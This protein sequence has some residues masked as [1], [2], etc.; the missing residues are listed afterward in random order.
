VTDRIHLGAITQFFPAA[1]VEQ[2]L[3]ETGRQS[4]RIRQ[5]PARVMVYYVIA[6]A[7]WMDVSCRE[8]LRCLLEGLSP[9]AGVER[10]RRSARSAISM[11][12]GRLGPEPLQ[13]LLERCVGPIATPATRGAWYRGLRLVSLDGSSLDVADTP[14][15]AR[16]FGRPGASRGDSAYPKLRFV[17]L[18]ESGT[19][20]L[21]RTAWGGFREAETTLA[22]RLL[23]GL[24]PGM[25][26][27]ADRGF[28]GFALWQA[29][30]ATGA[31]LVWRVKRNL[32]LPCERCL[33]DGSY[34][35]QIFPSQSDRRRRRGG[36]PVRVIEY[37]AQRARGEGERIRLI[38][39]LLDE[40]RAPA[41]ELAALYHERW[42]IENTLDELKTHLRG[43]QIVLRSQKPDLVEQEFYGL[44]LAHF[45][46][47][48]LMHEAAHRE[49]IDPDTLSFVHSFR[50][51]KRKL[52]AFLALPPSGVPQAA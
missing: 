8:V 6:M 12:R 7:L 1:Q 33:A 37:V 24:R 19:H 39:T 47:R 26:C 21:F 51:V 9:L 46:I 10:I 2:I 44:L 42:E 4:Q 52:P 29:A 3:V 27:F 23:D 45:A 43:R 31:E 11:A 35:S 50:V 30:R 25:L 14:A 36:Q 22:R 18:L 48:G 32:V 20:V 49:D 5:L 15:N 38:T 34:L 13:R 16:A 17:S 28:F 40:T 41:L